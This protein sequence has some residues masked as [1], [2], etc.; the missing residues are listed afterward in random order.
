MPPTDTAGLTD[1]LARRLFRRAF[2]LFISFAVL[3]T[4]VLV[5]ETLWQARKN[6]QGELAIYQRTFEKPLAAA[7]WAMDHEKLHS[8]VQGIIEIPDIK[9]VRILEPT[10]EREIVRAGRI[11]RQDDEDGHALAHRF[12]VIHDEGFGS[13]FVARAELHSSFGQLFE[14][15]RRQIVLIA[16]LATLKT[17][18]LWWIFLL[19]G[20]NIL[21]RPLS[22]IGQAMAVAGA[23]RSLSLSKETERAIAGTELD[24]LRQAHDRL[25][26]HAG[27][28]Q[29]QLERSNHELE[30]RVRA[31]T[32]QLEEANRRLD[33][34]A[35]T[36]SLTG[37]SNRR[38]F[39]SAAHDAVARARRGARPLALIV[40]DI[41]QFKR[42]NDLHGHAAGDRAIIHVADCLRDAV[43]EIDL[44]TRFGGDEF[45]ILMPGIA[46]GEAAAA[47]QRLCRRVEAAPLALDDGSTLALTLSIGVAELEEGDTRV[48]EV[49]LRADERLYQAKREGRNRVV[50]GMPRAGSVRT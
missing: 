35:H 34:L 28:V 5:G 16:V 36:D 41:D 50:D 3:L 39:L 26:E 33:A 9:G 38:H 15:T 46:T 49:L 13:E 4:L 42:V 12:N 2:G 30:Q 7:L 20:R 10:G 29:A 21:G 43:R 40:C 37:L 11:A 22:E 24:L 45:A 14:R 6:L 25:A 8:L 19:V 17:A 1:P 47:A 23:V 31:R 27:A 32:A 18:A 48:E 44:V